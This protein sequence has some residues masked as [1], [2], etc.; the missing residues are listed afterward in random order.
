MAVSG[1]FHADIARKDSL[2]L[3]GGMCS[4]Q[5]T[6]VIVGLDSMHVTESES[7]KPRL[8]M[9]Q[10]CKGTV[11]TRGLHFICKALNFWMK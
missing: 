4:M 1:R 11:Q 5:Q 2:L 8:L 6:C 7:V 3:H 10:I 9:Q